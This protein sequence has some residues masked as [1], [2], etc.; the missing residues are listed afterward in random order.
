MISKG[1]FSVYRTWQKGDVREVHFRSEANPDKPE[2][3]T[4]P[5]IVGTPLDCL[6]DLSSTAIITKNR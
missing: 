1:I 3:R 4:D 6:L 2:E 5:V